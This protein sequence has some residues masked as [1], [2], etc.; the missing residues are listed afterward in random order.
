MRPRFGSAFRKHLLCG[1]HCI[2]NDC[3]VTLRNFNLKKDQK[4]GSMHYGCFHFNPD[5]KEGLGYANY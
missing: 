3:N 1:L 2:Q 4:H 5:L